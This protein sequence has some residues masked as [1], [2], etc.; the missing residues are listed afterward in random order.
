MNWCS[1][2][3]IFCVQYGII[4]QTFASLTSSATTFEENILKRLSENEILIEK[5]STRVAYLENRDKV[6]Q[7]EIQSL[8]KQLELRKPW[9]SSLEQTVAHV[10]AS[11]HTDDT[12]GDS[13]EVSNEK[14]ATGTYAPISVPRKQNRILRD[15]NET[16]VA[17]FATV[18]D[19]HID[20]AAANQ[21][22]VFDNAITNVGNAY[23]TNL[24]TF[25][26]PVPGIYVFST[27]LFSV[28]DVSFHAGFVKNGKVLTSMYITGQESHFD[29]SSQTIV[30]QLQT[31]DDVHVQNNDANHSI[32][33]YGHS[34]LSGFLLQQDYSNQPGL[35]K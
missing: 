10:L 24:G 26:A 11:T 7:R 16:P 30:L 33:G 17:F 14:Q 28:H 27:T 6:Q 32:H 5:L 9:S 19:H 1:F 2:V 35:G 25:T 12:D 20:H 15:V 3:L 18:G 13:G 21:P 23:N 34:L 22:V 29:T 31:G 4:H 8:T